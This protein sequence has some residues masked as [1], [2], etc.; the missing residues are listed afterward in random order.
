MS[1]ELKRL[2][3]FERKQERRCMH[4]NRRTKLQCERSV[5]WIA[6][7]GFKVCVDHADR[8]GV[9]LTPIAPAATTKE[10]K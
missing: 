9:R 7:D 8:L 1:D 10:P 4:I 3:S 6:A 2:A 5:Y